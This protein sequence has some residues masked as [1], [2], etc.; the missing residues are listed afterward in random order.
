M[1]SI[2]VTEEIFGQRPSYTVESS[3]SR[4]F[5]V[6]VDGFVF[7][8]R[9]FSAYR[10]P[11]GMSKEFPEVHDFFGAHFHQDWTV[12]HDTAEQVIDAFLI[13]SDP[14]DLRRV[15]QE[16]DTLLELRKD[17]VGLREYLLKELRCY[18]CYWDAWESGEAWLRHIAG[19][20]DSRLGRPH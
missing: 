11:E 18:Y 8:R 15:R 20:L 6:K 5:F 10:V 2:N 16:L 19:K 7:L 17:E 14:E 13:D 9:V 1:K 3:A 4:S 12:E